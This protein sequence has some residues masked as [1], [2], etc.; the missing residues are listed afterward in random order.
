[1]FLKIFE[2]G[3]RKCGMRF[4]VIS[5]W[6]ND[7]VNQVQEIWI[8]SERLCPYVSCLKNTRITKKKLFSKNDAY[9]GRW[10]YTGVEAYCSCSVAV[11]NKHRGYHSHRQISKLLLFKILRKSHKLPWMPFPLK[12]LRDLSFI[13]VSSCYFFKKNLTK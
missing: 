11:N 7:M 6:L 8:L 3:P 12:G 9:S 5:P 13:M 2:K 4:S 1:M 10:Q